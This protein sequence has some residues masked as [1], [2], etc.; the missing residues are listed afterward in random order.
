[1]RTF[2][3]QVAAGIQWLD[4]HEPEWLHRIDVT[5][6]NMAIAVLTD[7]GCGCIG[8]Q[9]GRDGNYHNWKRD[10]RLGIDEL[11]S[12]GFDCCSWDMEVSQR[13]WKNT[14][15]ILRKQRGK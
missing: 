9:L 14:I 5:K 13:E 8:A 2:E 6:L 4:E 7:E 3:S 10:H 12:L 11:F 15:K 1:M